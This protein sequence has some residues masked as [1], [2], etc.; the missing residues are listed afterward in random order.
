MSLKYPEWWR[1][2]ITIYSLSPSTPYNNV[3]VVAVKIY[4]EI[5]GFCF[6]VHWSERYV[7]V[8][9][10]TQM[11][12]HFLEVAVLWDCALA[13]SS[14]CHSN[15]APKTHHSC[16]NNN[17]NMGSRRGG[18]NGHIYAHHMCLSRSLIYWFDKNMRV[19]KA[20]QIF[21]MILW[22][23]WHHFYEVLRV[24]DKNLLNR[25]SLS[26]WVSMKKKNDFKRWIFENQL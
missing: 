8:H 2:K 6:F 24:P 9:I 25:N 26:Y 19:K 23:F 20:E 22:Y 10:H 16:N 21:T 5:W 7:Y 14:F 1:Y 13:F 4:I 15:S 3:V 11:I 18:L 12:Y 17:E